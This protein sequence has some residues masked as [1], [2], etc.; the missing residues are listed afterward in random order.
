MKLILMK[1]I[2]IKVILF[3]PNFVPNYPSLSLA[4]LSPSL[5]Q[6]LSISFNQESPFILPISQPSKIAQIWL[7]IQNLR[8]DLSF[9][10]KKTI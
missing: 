2:L 5:F 8:M 4:Q 6:F 1:F 3:E 9:Q 7:C 10:E